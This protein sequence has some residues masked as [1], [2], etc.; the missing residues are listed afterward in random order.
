MSN[1]TVLLQTDPTLMDFVAVTWAPPAGV[2]GGARARL[3]TITQLKALLI[4]GV[5]A[6]RAFARQIST[7]RGSRRSS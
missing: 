3:N 6:A 1:V 7:I 2:F 5:L 4:V